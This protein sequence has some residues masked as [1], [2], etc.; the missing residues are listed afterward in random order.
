MRKEQYPVAG[1]AL[2]ATWTRKELEAALKVSGRTLDRLVRKGQFPAP[3]YVGRACRWRDEGC[4][5][6]PL[7][8]AAGRRGGL[9]EGRF[10]EFSSPRIPRSVRVG[11]RGRP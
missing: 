6:R 4:G 1:P 5:H 3:I 8:R 10:R 9:T 7:H 11:S 2:E